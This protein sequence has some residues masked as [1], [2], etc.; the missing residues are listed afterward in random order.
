M[1]T[2]D[3]NLEPPSQTLVAVGAVVNAHGP[4]GRIRVQPHSSDPDRFRRGARL[5]I[6]GR[7]LAVERVQRAAGGGVLLKLDGVDT[8]QQAVELRGETIEVAESDLPSPPPD[9]YYHYQL[10][11]MTVVDESG[12]EI[13]TLTEI[14]P[15][16]GANDV[17]V[18]VSGGAELLLPALGGRHPERGHR[19]PAH[20]GRRS[21]G[22]RMALARNAQDQAPAPEAAS[23]RQ[24]SSSGRR[25]HQGERLES[26]PRL[27][28][29]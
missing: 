22:T 4:D 13:G 1:A 19:G 16:G 20:D 3:S 25:I 29:F 10:L 6:A 18:V 21:P 28:L 11:D 7:S 12:A 5:L 14:V 9:V 26:T 2:V 27:A 8:R 15:A 23:A 24:L 17:Y